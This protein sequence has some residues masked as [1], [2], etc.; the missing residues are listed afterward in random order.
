MSYSFS[1]TGNGDSSSDS[2][3][4]TINPEST[5]T[6]ITCSD[7][8]YDGTDQSGGCSVEV[9]GD[10]SGETY[11]SGD[12]VTCTGDCSSVGTHYVSYIF[13]AAGNGY[14]SSDSASF[15]VYPST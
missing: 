6:T 2:T 15:E 4:F 7:A 3:S 13:I 8:T 5:T 12:S 14:S 11:V 10:N 9:T 1:A